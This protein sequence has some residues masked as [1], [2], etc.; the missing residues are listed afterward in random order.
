MATQN[1]LNART[2]FALALNQI[3]AERG[4]TVESVLETIKS[5]ILAAY[6]KDF[7]LEEE[8]DYEVEVDPKTGDA[9]IFEKKAKTRKNITPPG[10]GRIAAQ[11]AKQVI[12]QKIREAEK[13]AILDE[14]Q[15][16]IGQLVSGMILRF[17]GQDIV[18]DIGR[19]QGRMPLEEQVKSER[20]KLNQR[21]TLYILDIKETARGKQIIVSRA[22]EQLVVKLFEREVPE[23]NSGAV[24][25]KLVAREPGNRS[26]VAVESTQ[27]GVDPVG[28]CVGQKGVRVQA[29]I[30]ELNGEKIDI[31]QYSQ[32]TEKFIAAALSPAES[33]TIKLNQK[34]K[35][36]QVS[37]PEEQLSLAIGRDGQ[38]VRLAARLTGFK[39]D[40][41][42][43]KDAKAE[44]TKDTKVKKEKKTTKTKK[45][46]K[47]GETTKAKKEKKKSS[48][49][50]KAK[51]TKTKKKKSK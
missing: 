27:P 43:A 29:V 3:C 35:T 28:S 6:R 11:T 1:L 10:F 5:A 39:I 51:K 13:S 17:D 2:E 37:A 7:G 33:L 34:R 38:N 32:E 42:N 40:I 45:E 25:I 30:D 47:A 21:L 44:K 20:Y 9:K 16:K 49:K 31:I 46:K 8:I 22:S 48:Q 19:G 18:C 12:L 24:K 14:Y 41:K 50:S 4:I 23:V 26:K 36:A 15:E